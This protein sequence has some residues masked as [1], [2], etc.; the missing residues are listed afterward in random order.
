MR[1]KDPF[2]IDLLLHFLLPV[3]GEE[4]DIDQSHELLILLEFDVSSTVVEEKAPELRSPL[5]ETRVPSKLS[6]FLSN[7]SVEEVD[8]CVLGDIVTFLL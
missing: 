6:L 7:Q 3:V 5:V 1:I 8:L 4:G 2:L